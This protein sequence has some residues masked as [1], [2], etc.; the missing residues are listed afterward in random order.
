MFLQSKVVDLVPNP[1]SL[2][3]QVSV[4]MSPSDRVS[5]LYLQ[6]AGSIF[7]AFCYSQGCSGNVPIRLHTGNLYSSPN[8]IKTI[9]LRMGGTYSTYVRVSLRH[10]LCQMWNGF[11]WTLLM[12]LCR[13]AMKRAQQDT[14]T[15]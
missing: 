3:V 15:E 1:P 4:V 11:H 5:Q 9:R 8:I 12:L 2:E 7:V 10:T 6:A 13:C 14:C